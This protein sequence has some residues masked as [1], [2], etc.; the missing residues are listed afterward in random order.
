[1]S[2]TLK[3]LMAAAHAAVP[4]IAPEQAQKLLAGGQ[5]IAVDV[6]DPGEVQAS[7]KIKGAVQASRGH[8]EFKIDPESPHFDPALRKDKTILVYCA[9]GGRSTLAG[10]TLKDMGF[11]D[12]RNLGGFKD[13]VAGG[14]AVEKVG[15][16]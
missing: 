5:A 15:A 4:V 8:L 2:T 3:E 11:A 10:K 6:R 13:W 14:G 16:V 7:G 9:S 12:V 1:M